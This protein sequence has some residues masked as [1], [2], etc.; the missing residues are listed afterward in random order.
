MGEMGVRSEDVT[1]AALSDTSNSLIVL[2]RLW[3]LISNPFRTGEAQE[4]LAGS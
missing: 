4:W 3:R 1:Q 2:F